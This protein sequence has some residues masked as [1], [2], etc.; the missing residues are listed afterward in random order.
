MEAPINRFHHVNSRLNM[1]ANQ[2]IHLISAT[3]LINAGEKTVH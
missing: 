3:D 2:I 1:E